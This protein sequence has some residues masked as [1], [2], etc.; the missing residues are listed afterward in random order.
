MNEKQRRLLERLIKAYT[1]RMPPDIGAA[2]RKDAEVAGL[3]K[4]YFAWAGGS[5]PGQPH[6][7]RVQGPTFLIEFLDVQKDSAGNPA[8]HIHSCWRNTHGDFGT[9]SE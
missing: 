3:D 7:Y 1:D 8:N 6:T 2:E 5:E 4:V 9:P